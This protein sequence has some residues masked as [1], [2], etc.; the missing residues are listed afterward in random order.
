MGG[1]LNKRTERTP[2]PGDYIKEKPSYKGHYMGTSNRIPNM[3]PERTPG[4]GQYYLLH[5]V[6]NVPEYSI[7]KSREHKYR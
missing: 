4:P 5:N 7:R 2:G 6:S 3:A 1:I